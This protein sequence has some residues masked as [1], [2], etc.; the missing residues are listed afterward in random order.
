MWSA[1]KP[2]P[3]NKRIGRFEPRYSVPRATRLRRHATSPC[4][5]VAD[6]KHGEKALR[7][8]DLD[9]QLLE[10][11]RNAAIGRRLDTHVGDLVAS[12]G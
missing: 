8:R 12:D 9:S 1:D 2:F 6:G 5:S 3:V 7:G 4:L 11:R 10:R